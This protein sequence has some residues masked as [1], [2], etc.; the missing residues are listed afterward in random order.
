MKVY[1]DNAATTPLAPEVIQ[2]MFSVM[3]EKFGNPSSIH[4]YGREARSLIEQ[5]RKYIAGLFNVTPGEI[6]F[7][8]GA[9]EANNMAIR[10]SV[11]DLGIR[12][13][14]SSPIEHHAVEHTLQELSQHGKI[15]LVLL[16]NAGEF[17]EVDLTELEALLEAHKNEKLMVSLMHANNELGTINPI[18]EIGELC[19]KY[20]A[21]YH[22]DT[23][24]SVA[25]YDLDLKEI[26]VDFITC[27]AHK[28]HGP[29]GVGFLYINN[30]IKINPMLTG[31][32]QERNM[33][34]GTE[35]IYGIAGMVKALQLSYNNLEK[36]RQY[37]TSLRQHMIDKLKSEMPGVEFYSDLDHNSLYTVLSVSF[38]P[39]DFAEMFL[40]TLDI[41][42]IAASSGSA[43]SSG[44]STGSHVL[45]A[46][47][48]NGDRPA[49]R[50][51]FSRYNTREEIDYTIEKL[52]EMYM[53]KA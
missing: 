50:F 18:K 30:R 38:P 9:T 27:S 45:I 29:K 53:V 24:Q 47:G 36:E 22:A 8:S 44:S 20:H 3:Q 7:T 33:R 48:K 52:K 37:I 28:F 21:V 26:P 39:C 32:S 51:S 43:C 49:V 2:E 5:G 15:K 11:R 34:G 25:H 12:C 4:S 31:G 16:K 1:L 13:V 35:N 42:G 41:N 14:I 46:L 19:Q 6:F 23:V 40:F 17:G 10:C